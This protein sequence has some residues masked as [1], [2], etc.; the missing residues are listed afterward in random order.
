M[1]TKVR[2]AVVKPGG[3]LWMAKGAI[4]TDIASKNLETIRLNADHGLKVLFT[5]MHAVILR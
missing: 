5:L 2:C 3:K 4:A 1:K